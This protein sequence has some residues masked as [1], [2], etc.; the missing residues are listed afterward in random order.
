MGASSQGV[1]WWR[2][3]FPRKPS[4]L[5]A[6]YDWFTV[7]RNPMSRMVSEFH[8]RW[9]GVGD[10]VA[11][12]NVSSFNEFLQR[13]I[14]GKAYLGVGDHYSAQ[15]LYMDPDIPVRVL[16]FENLTAEFDEL[17]TEYGLD[18]S[19][20]FANHMPHKFSERDFYPSTIA[21]I[22]ETYADDF[23][24]FGYPTGIANTMKEGG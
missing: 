20:Q 13:N 16:C 21:L 17:M 5:K 18:V 23:T 10:N 11:Q 24:L 9:G 6:K 4:A 12:H 8:C 14:I 15:V 19:L 3:L 2:E 1:G 22:R 7:V